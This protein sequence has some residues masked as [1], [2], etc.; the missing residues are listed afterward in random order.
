MGRHPFT[1]AAAI[2]I[3]PKT[4]NPIRAIGAMID[5]IKPPGD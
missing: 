4:Y 3:P 2:A 5:L 1:A